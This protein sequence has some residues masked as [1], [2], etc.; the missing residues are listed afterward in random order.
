[1]RQI[2]TFILVLLA[3]TGIAQRADTLKAIPIKQCRCDQ[4]FIQ[5]VPSSWSR[6]AVTP[7]FSKG[8]YESITIYSPNGGDYVRIFPSG[9]ID[10]NGSLMALIKK[11]AECSLESAKDQGDQSKKYLAAFDAMRFV[12]AKGRIKNKKQFRH[13]VKKYRQ[14]LSKQ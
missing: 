11:W 2:L 14:L 10:V 4:T 8:A 6:G 3:I 13:A 5:W 9:S 1:M 7:D 12:D